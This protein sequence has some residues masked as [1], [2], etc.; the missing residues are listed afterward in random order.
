MCMTK[1]RESK[2]TFR[3]NKRKEYKNLIAGPPTNVMIL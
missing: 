3:L 1:A 2:F